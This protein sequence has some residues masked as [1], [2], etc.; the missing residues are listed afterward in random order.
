MGKISH[1][2]INTVLKLSGISK[3]I[4]NQVTL[5]TLI[6]KDRPAFMK[7]LHTLAKKEAGDHKRDSLKIMTEKLQDKDV[8]WLVSK[9]SGLEL[10]SIMKG[11][12]DKVTGGMLSY[13]S[14]QSDLSAPFLKIL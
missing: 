1:G 3:F 12:E 10:F 13:A 14:S 9:Y 5:R 8:N 11:Q 6:K 2:P 4:T 7:K